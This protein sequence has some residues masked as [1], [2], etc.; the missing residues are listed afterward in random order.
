[1]S[2]VQGTRSLYIKKSIKLN[3]Y[4][5]AYSPRKFMRNNGGYF[6][7]A[8]DT[9]YLSMANRP[10]QVYLSQNDMEKLASG[11]E[12]RKITSLAFNHRWTL[13]RP[14][15]W[16]PL[17]S[18]SEVERMAIVMHDHYYRGTFKTADV[19]NGVLRLEEASGCTEL[20]ESEHYQG[21]MED[22]YAMTWW[23]GL[24]IV[25]SLC[26]IY[27]GDKKIPEQRPY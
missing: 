9:L 27:R 15:S 14:D 6:Y 19:P 26:Y 4:A 8:K 22:E 11:T 10:Q 21:L 16:E 20:V 25:R 1:M 3:V 5:P 24:P 2:T 18:F 7:P 23:I 12:L 17:E 13:N